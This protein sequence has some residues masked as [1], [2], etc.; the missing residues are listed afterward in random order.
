M[1][2][3]IVLITG[4]TGGIGLET[5]R[6]LAR[7]GAR[8]VIGAR[9]AAKGQA[10]VTE[11]ANAGGQ[12]EFLRIDMASFASI[13]EAAASLAANHPKLDVLVNNAGV[14][15]KKREVNADGHE[16]IWATNFLG[17]LLL[18]RLLLPQLLAAPKPRVVNVS[19][20][21]HA[22]GRINWQDLE[23][24]KGWRGI[25][26]YANSKLALVLFTRELARRE[27]RIAANAVHP[28]AIATGIWRAAPQPF[29][30]FLDLFL[31][32]PK[33]GA[34]PVVRLAAAPEIERVSGRYFD[35]QRL[36][37]PA[38]AAS[39][40]ADAARLWDLTKGSLAI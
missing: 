15:T 17:P 28:G 1:T 31:P 37:V 20:M 40:D 27:P 21:A 3:R 32:S 34:R 11:I 26:A 33:K 12:A 24:T 29:R 7:K 38:P 23:L 22:Y 6:E 14:V 2:G 25:R 36:V 16:V 10:V 18:T 35:R 13:R 19:S 39:N 8:V 5:A 4:A 30:F 9:N